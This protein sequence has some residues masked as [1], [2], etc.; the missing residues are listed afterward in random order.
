MYC[1]VSSINRNNIKIINFVFVNH[2]DK[3]TA[4][5]FSCTIGRLTCIDECLLP[6]PISGPCS[7]F[8]PDL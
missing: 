6:E 4:A 3:I 5:C 7:N 8:L 1:V 2:F